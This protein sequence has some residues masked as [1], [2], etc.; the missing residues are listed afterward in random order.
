M[1]NTQQPT[2]LKS[3]F[4]SSAPTDNVQQS[5]GNEILTI[6]E[7]NQKKTTKSPE[8]I[9]QTVE[10]QLLIIQPNLE[11]EVFVVETR[12]GSVLPSN[13][14]KFHGFLSSLL[15]YSASGVDDDHFYLGE[16]E[17]I[18]QGLVNL[19]LFISKVATDSIVYESCDPDKLGCGIWAFDTTFQ[20][21]AR[22]QCSIS[23]DNAGL[24]CLN[25]IIGCACI[26]G[27][28][29]HRI[30][31]KSMN[32]STPYSDVQFCTTDPYESVC[33][34]Y[35]EKGEETRW[36]P[37][38]AYWVSF[39]Q[40]YQSINPGLEESTYMMRLQRFVQNGR[41]D[42]TFLDYVVDIN[43]HESI[44]KAPKEKF[45]EMYYKII[46]LLMDGLTTAVKQQPSSNPTNT[47]SQPPTNIAVATAQTQTPSLPFDNAQ[48]I[49][50]DNQSF[51]TPDNQSME[52]KC[53][54]LCV[55]PI[56]TIECPP[57]GQ[58]LKL[59][60]SNFIGVDELCIASYGECDTIKVSVND[61]AISYNV[62]R[63][64]DCALLVDYPNDSESDTE[65]DADTL[66]QLISPV[67][68][69]E[70][71]ST[72]S[73]SKSSED[74]GKLD[75]AQPS[76]SMPTAKPSS[77][78]DGIVWWENISSTSKQNYHVSIYPAV[79]LIATSLLMECLAY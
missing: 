36:L 19:A 67:P 72:V 70:P 61:C 30:G 79:I 59:C 23:S 6:P 29:D 21:N 2:G 22:F 62:F 28:L 51:V 3:G 27:M 65:L 40:R 69:P 41:Q 33:S 47:P 8:H 7:T 58:K 63:R 12:G 44:E 68:T 26:L 53:P 35:L 31:S 20:D 15:Y 49:P 50:V 54:L 37:A 24:E 10:N 52:T 48:T 73:P 56:K 75:S 13:V 34:K 32:E 55:V 77:G 71:S 76:P 18:E 57:R 17:T 66:P 1:S 4:I 9:I 14:Y 25:G 46:N 74:R 16:D 60:F 38:M 78:F 64:I 42:A 5:L 39:V 11:R 43:I 45:A